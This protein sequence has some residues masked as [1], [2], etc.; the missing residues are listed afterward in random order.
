MTVTNSLE[1]LATLKQE[2]ANTIQKIK[3]KNL[4]LRVPTRL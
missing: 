3:I 2:R 4:A 1:S